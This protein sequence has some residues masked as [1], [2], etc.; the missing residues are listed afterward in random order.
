MGP[1]HATL[2][3][4]HHCGQRNMRDMPFAQE[5]T[6][7]LVWPGE[8]PVTAALPLEGN[9]SGCCEVAYQQ[10]PPSH[11]HTSQADRCINALKHPQNCP[12]YAS[13]VSC[14]ALAQAAW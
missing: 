10:V 14:T 2:R 1:E 3:H 11:P 8:I 4:V 13:I 7:V 5:Q 12:P 9:L 6:I